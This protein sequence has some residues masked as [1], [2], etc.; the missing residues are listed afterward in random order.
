MPYSGLWINDED[1]RRGCDNRKRRG[2]A[3][4]M[5]ALGDT[6]ALPGPQFQ[7]P[8]YRDLGRVRHSR[9]ELV[10]ADPALAG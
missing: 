3:A 10:L 4:S 8:A 9:S 2:T 7:A 1:L 5:E 6:D